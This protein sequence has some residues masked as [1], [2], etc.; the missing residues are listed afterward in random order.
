[1]KITNTFSVQFVIRTKKSNAAIAIIYA[2]I[3]ANKKRLEIS[4]KRDTESSLWDTAGEC[5]KGN[6]P[7]AKQLNKF[8]ADV[9]FKLMDC[10]HQLQMQN[11]VITAEAIKRLFHGETRLENALC[12]LMEYHNENMKTVLASG[13]LKN[14]YTTEKY[15]K[16]SLAKRH[17][18][19]DIFLS[20][21]TT[22]S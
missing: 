14:Y 8:I 2:R 21:L 13:T 11:K 9:R 16:L 17:G 20:E 10:Y 5:I 12:G 22:S 7:E 19:T 15:V 1:M 6:K 4:L 18:A 3:N